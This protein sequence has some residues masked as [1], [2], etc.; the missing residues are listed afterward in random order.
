[1]PVSRIYV[2]KKPGLDTEAQLLCAELR[3]ALGASG[4]RAVRILQR[5][6]V[7]GFPAELL[8]TA[9]AT[10]FS[11]PPLDTLYKETPPPL[12]G[13]V[14]AVESLPGQFDQRADGA[15]QCL[16]LLTEE[17]RPTVTCAKVYALEGDIGEELFG[18]IRQY[19]IHPAERRD[20]SASDSPAAEPAPAIAGFTGL[21]RRKLAAAA[22][23]WGLALG[24][25]DLALCQAYFRDQ[26]QRDPTLAELRVIEACWTAPPPAFLSALGE[27][28]IDPSPYAA[29]IARAWQRYMELREAMDLDISEEINAGAIAVDAQVDGRREPWLVRFATEAC[30]CA[31]ETEAFGGGAVCLGGAIRDSLSDRAYAYQAMRISGS[32]DPRAPYDEARPGKLPQRRIT[33]AAARGSSAYGN[34]AGVAA[35]KVQEV[36]HPGFAARRFELA[37]VIAAA[38]AENLRRAAPEP[39]D[40]VLL[41]GGQKNNPAVARSLQRLFR[42]PDFSRRIKRCA[43][44]G[45]GGLCVAARKLAPG[46]R[47]G[48]DA[49]PPKL[50]LSESAEGVACVAGLREVVHILRLAAQGNVEC[51][52]IAEVT[53]APRLRMRRHGQDI[54]DIAREFLDAG[55]VARRVK[56]RIVAP[57]AAE[58]YPLR[59]PKTLPPPDALPSSDAPPLKERWLR[60]L[61][62]LNACSQRGLVERFDSGI[63]MGTVLAPHGG[64]YRGTPNEAMAALL[65]VPGSTTTMTL[66][67]HGCDPALSD[68]SPYHGAVYAVLEAVAKVVA[69]GGDAAACRLA[70]HGIFPRAGRDP[71]KWGAPVAA[72]LGALDARLAME[73]PALDAKDA[74]DGSVED[75]PGAP[76]APP[77]LVAFAVAVEDVV[78]VVT[79]ELKGPG[80]VLAR[81]TVPRDAALL[82]D[83]PALRAAY[84]ALHMAMRKRQILAAH[85]VGHG[86]LAAALTR[87]SLGSRVGGTILDEAISESDAVPEAILDEAIGEPGAVPEAILGEAIGEPGAAPEPKVDCTLFLPDWGGLV[88]ELADG[89]AELLTEG[90]GAVPGLS[91]IGHTTAEPVIA[92]GEMRLSLADAL[93]AW[94]APLAGVFPTQASALA[95]APPPPLAPYTRRGKAARIR[96]ARPRVCIPCFPGTN[97]E[98]DGARAFE[99]AGASADIVMFRNITPQAVTDSVRALVQAIGRAQIVM[100]PGGFSPGSGKFIAV[101]LR[102]PHVANAITD[103]LENRDGLMLGLCNGF[104]ALIKAGLLPYGAIRPLGERDPGLTI[105]TLGRTVAIYT[106]TVVSSVLSPWMAGAEPGQVHA[107]AMSH[108][109]GRFVCGEAQL[110]EL[111]AAGQIATQYCEP[112]GAPTMRSPHNPNG[113]AWAVEGICSPDGRILGKM[114]H[115]ERVGPGVAVNIPG[116]KDQRLFVSGVGYFA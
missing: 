77:T 109:E 14:F 103:L 62:D 30:N 93:A 96:T 88:L 69:A 24:S 49:L 89:A 48:L 72:M 12:P 22:K 13:K 55:G 46:L 19:L 39:G 17:R 9:L 94:E 41:L 10:I 58:P 1:M 52:L 106:H 73:I 32:G 43:A 54:V 64:A 91:I 3:E 57:D 34:Q 110:K 63:G 105:N 36:Y 97:C 26:E 71:A 50:A 98:V 27:V 60:L 116:E 95:I 25:D 84:D 74:K 61:G 81:L 51:T 102:N 66:V 101:V 92:C 38:P 59:L 108:G 5:Y 113:S 44:L 23:E 37:A 47:L 99:R 87:M 2:E 68:W 16:Q 15:A 31:T 42:N 82:P 6:D 112:D 18:R 79:P 90:A 75:E 78:R 115:S 56:A 100:L 45:A 76:E 114:G 104:Q 86:G 85:T 70:L 83:Y 53:E 4:L 65:P 29:P 80:H 33:A 107:V 20:A 35:G 67:A 21:S 28:Q 8:D 111:Y 40:A 7:E 11:E